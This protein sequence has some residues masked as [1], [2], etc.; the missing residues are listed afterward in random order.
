M[1][2]LA[3][4]VAV[5]AVAHP[6]PLPV[7]HQICSVGLVSTDGAL[8]TR[9][10]GVTANRGSGDCGDGVTSHVDSSGLESGTS[11]LQ[12]VTKPDTS[13]V[14]LASAWPSSLS[15]RKRRSGR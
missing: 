5:S 8:R 9:K 14:P 15:Q 6:A 3:V 7:G 12:E 1:N 10:S 4:N 2:L 13:T 11:H